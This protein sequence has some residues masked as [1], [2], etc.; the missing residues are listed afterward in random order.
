MPSTNAVSRQNLR[1]RRHQLEQLYLR[2]RRP[3]HGRA[4]RSDRRG[5]TRVHLIDDMPVAMVQYPGSTSPATY[6]IHTG[7]IGEPL[8][9]TDASK[10]IVWNNVM[11]PYGTATPLG[12]DTVT[13]DL[14]YPGQWLQPETGGLAQNWFR[15]YDASLGRYTEADP[16]GLAGGPNVYAYAGGVPTNDFDA[17]GAAPN[18]FDLIY[19]T[20]HCF[21]A[22]ASP[23]DIASAKF[24]NC[25]KGCIDDYYFSGALGIAA[26][27]AGQRSLPYPRSGISGGTGGTS[28]ASK[29]SRA[30]FRLKLP[31][32]LGALS[33]R[34]LGALVGRAVPYVGWGFARLR[35]RGNSCMYR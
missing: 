5:H 3:S 10:A 20:S 19:S 30:I 4:R 18:A 26:V 22:F 17:S 13:L 29:V 9:M 8:M 2:R 34:S 6:Y 12:T 28:V 15:D 7:Q 35:R 27:A 1:W 33:T 24:S 21:D 14:R 11:D 16:L 32:P 25:L 31:P 23:Q